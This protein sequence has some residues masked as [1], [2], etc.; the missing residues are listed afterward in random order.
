MASSS[1]DPSNFDPASAFFTEIHGCVARLRVSPFPND[2]PGD[3]TWWILDGTLLFRYEP[4]NNDGRHPVTAFSNEKI[5]HAK[6][7]EVPDDMGGGTVVIID[8]KAAQNDTRISPSL[9]QSLKTAAPIQLLSENNHFSARLDVGLG[10]NQ[11]AMRV[12]IYDISRP[13]TRRTT[14]PHISYKHAAETLAEGD[15][16]ACGDG[17]DADSGRIRIPEVWAHFEHNG[18]YY[19][20]A[21][22]LPGIS[23][24]QVPA[25]PEK[26]AVLSV[27]GPVLTT[28]NRI[29]GLRKTAV[30]Q[31]LNRLHNP[32]I[33]MAILFA[34]H[35]GIPRHSN[36]LAE[37]R[38]KGHISR[39]GTGRNVDTFLTVGDYSESNI[40]VDMETLAFVGFQDFSRA[41]FAPAFW[42][43]WT[44]TNRGGGVEAMSI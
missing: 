28:I 8:L 21:E 12:S 43:N 7:L 6:L 30:I 11:A 4:S 17:R 39:S 2:E 29:R 37:M 38:E 31:G 14:R 32:D 19:L 35:T 22:R 36:L 15:L 34:G 42:I 23:L 10:T 24:S 44:M 16:I 3:N 5:A 9:V 40:I 41:G 20:F 18:R 27:T 33:V 1:S 26:T 25:S 13:Q